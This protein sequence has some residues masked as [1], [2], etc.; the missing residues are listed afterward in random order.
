MNKTYKQS[1]YQKTIKKK[2]SL[3]GV[4]LHTG[5]NSIVNF[6][7]AEENSGIRFKRLDLDGGNLKK[8]FMK[9]YIKIDK[10]MLKSKRSIKNSLTKARMKLDYIFSQKGLNIIWYFFII[11]IEI[12]P[13]IK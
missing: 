1:I 2:V 7:P 11:V 10:N 13:S 12:L 8:W 3:K 6:K 5:V 9:I 4:G